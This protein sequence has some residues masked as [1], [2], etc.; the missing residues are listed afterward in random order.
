MLGKIT[1]LQVIPQQSTR[2]HSKFAITYIPEKPVD[3]F[4]LLFNTGVDF[5]LRNN[6]ANSGFFAKV[7][8]PVHI[9]NSLVLLLPIEGV[10]S[11]QVNWFTPISHLQ[12]K[13]TSMKRQPLTGQYFL[14]GVLKPRLYLSLV[15]N[16][17]L[18]VDEYR[19]SVLYHEIF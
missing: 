3:C 14:L 17:T 8:V 10:V 5:S 11:S 2:K 16:H 15:V 1:H 18:M 13:A 7:S 9:H 6:F 12:L 4:F 19:Y